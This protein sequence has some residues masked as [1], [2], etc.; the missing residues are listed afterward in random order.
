MTGQHLP[1]CQ[2][3]GSVF[4]GMSFSLLLYG[5]A[6]AQV[7]YYS[8]AYPQDKRMTKIVVALLWLLDTSV[9]AI[10]IKF[11]WF[12][13]VENHSNQTALTTI[14]LLLSAEWAT[15]AVVVLLVQS[16]YVY[17]IWTLLMN[18]RCRA[19]FTFTAALLCLISFASGTALAVVAL[20]HDQLPALFSVIAVPASMQDITAA[21]ADIYISV[22]L[23]WILHASKTGHGRMDGILQ[24]IILYTVNRGLLTII[25]QVVL[26]GTYWGIIGRVDFVWIIPHFMESKVYVNSMLA[27]LNVRNHLRGANSLKVFSEFMAEDLLPDSPIT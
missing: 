26:W 12:Y 10:T 1:L 15:S 14:P 24:R 4:I 2:T 13:L 27:V 20:L 18:T 19:P 17:N 23:I 11:S 16:F 8:R 25:M 9:T 7:L 3:I 22:S 5:F 6:C 21:I